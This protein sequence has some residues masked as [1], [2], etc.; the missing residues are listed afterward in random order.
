MFNKL[1]K[2]GMGLLSNLTV[3]LNTSQYFFCC[4]VLNAL[5]LTLN[6]LLNLV[7]LEDFVANLLQSLTLLD[8][9]VSM[10]RDL[11]ATLYDL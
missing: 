10:L 2:N 1:V 5:S 9:R 3:L 6:H 4:L 8:C 11:S 7:L